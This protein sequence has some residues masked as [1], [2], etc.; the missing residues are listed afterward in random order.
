MFKNN[1]NIMGVVMNKI[2]LNSKVKFELKIAVLK[3]LYF[4][5]FSYLS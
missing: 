1:V 3:V 5:I 4:V 2:C